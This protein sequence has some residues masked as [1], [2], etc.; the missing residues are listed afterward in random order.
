LKT[1]EDNN[2]PG[3]PINTV[4]EVFAD[5]QVIHRGLQIAPEGVPGVRTPIVFSDA[6]LALDRPP[7][8]LGEHT[9]EILAE[10][11]EDD[12]A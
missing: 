4:D 3:G 12:R 6:E 2:V 7:P 5:P 1:L 8:L 10:L 11:E 9:D